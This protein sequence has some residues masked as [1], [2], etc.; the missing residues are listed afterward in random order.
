MS[1][2]PF[3]KSTSVSSAPFELIHTDLWGPSPVASKGGSVYYVSFIDDYSR[4][5][6]V[7]LMAHKSHFYQHFR[8]FHVMIQTQFS[9]SIKVLAEVRRYMKTFTGE[10]S[11]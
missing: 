3:H 10:T 5:T 1:A 2:L 8:T 11:K 6:W 4:Y 7:Y 9:A